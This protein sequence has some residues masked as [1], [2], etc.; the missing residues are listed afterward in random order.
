ML[1][2]RHTLAYI[3]DAARET[4]L[5][6]L[7]A[8]LPAPMRYSDMQDLV[9]EV[10]IEDRIPGIVCRPTGAVPEGGGQLGF[11]FPF[12]MGAARVRSAVPVAAGQVTSYVTPW[13]V[14]ALAQ[15]LGDTAH[16]VI[17]ALE[18]IG[19]RTG[20]QIGLIGSLAMKIV[21]GLGYLRPDSDIDIVLRAEDPLMLEAAQADLQML[22]ARTGLRIDAEVVLPEGTGVKLSELLSAADAVLGKTISGVELISRNRLSEIMSLRQNSV[23]AG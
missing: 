13:E 12:R 20:V 23:I 11:A 9:T 5:P 1:Q 4:L 10:F 17:A 16:P 8:A 2:T 15:M 7:L 19:H 18:D 6:A 3:E 14:M 22:S 21:T